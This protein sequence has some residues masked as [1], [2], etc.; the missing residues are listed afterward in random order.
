[1]IWEHRHRIPEGLEGRSRVR[2]GVMLHGDRVIFYTADARIVALDARDGTRLWETPPTGSEDGHAYAYSSTGIVAEG[3][4]ISGTVGCGRF[5]A[6]SCFVSA[7]DAST[8][9]LLWRTNTIPGP[10]EPGGDTWAGLAAEFR[11][12]GEVWTTGTFDPD[13]RLLYWGV[14]QAKPWHR[15]S[16]QT[17][18][19]AL[20]YTASTLAL[21]PDTGE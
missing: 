3:K 9:A 18:D 1:L 12:G 17:G 21:D 2:G 6:G 4:V 19:A 13:L 10:D 15:E 20:L 8:G 11:A 16:R 5:L 7:H 14:A